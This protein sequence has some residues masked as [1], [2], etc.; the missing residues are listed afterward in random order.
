MPS[1]RRFIRQTT[2]AMAGMALAG[3]ALR[4][5]AG[6]QATRREVVVGGRRIKTVDVHA[7]CEIPGIREMVGDAPTANPALT[8]GADRL[9]AMDAQ[10]IDVEVLSINP[11]W[12]AVDRDLAPRLIRAQNEGLAA[13][14]AARPDR[15]VA[16]ATTTLQHP[17]LAAVQ[18][19]EGSRRWGCGAAR[20][21]RASGARSWPP[22]ASIRSGPR[23]R[24]WTY[25]SSCI[26]RAC[27]SSRR[28]CRETAFSATRSAIR[29][30]R[31]SP[32]PI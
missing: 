13:I 24:S 20:S 15:F 25:P 27:R 18:L 3:A 23:P 14:C 29:W 5:A 10:G 1:R 26:R 9:R 12:Y 28:G 19:E 32:C 4:G 8:I 2:T 6:T 17:D 11:F 31:Q 16:L 22:A 21:G 7:H 30:R